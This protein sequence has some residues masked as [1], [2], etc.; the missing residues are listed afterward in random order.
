[1]SRVSG[2]INDR[3]MAS[4]DGMMSHPVEVLFARSGN[5][6]HTNMIQL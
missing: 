2:P 5:S 1:M 4:G 6:G 3:M